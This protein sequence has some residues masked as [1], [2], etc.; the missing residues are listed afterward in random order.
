MEDWAEHLVDRA[1]TDIGLLTNLMRHL[2]QRE[3]EV[4]LAEHLVYERHAVE[5]M[6]FGNSRNVCIQKR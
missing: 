3:L 5:G 6:R 2:L 1:R 4:E